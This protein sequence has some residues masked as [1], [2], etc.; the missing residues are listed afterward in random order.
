MFHL[1]SPGRLHVRCE[2]SGSGYGLSV[3]FVAWWG[4]GCGDGHGGVLL[5]GLSLHFWDL[6]V[7]FS[8]HARW[9]LLVFLNNILLLHLDVWYLQAQS[10]SFTPGAPAIH[11]SSTVLPVV[12]LRHVSTCMLR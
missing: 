5:D 9:H 8:V 7:L 2:W 6:H 11:T 3:V 1:A 4:L 12:L 10:F